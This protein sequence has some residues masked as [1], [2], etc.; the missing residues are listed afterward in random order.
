MRG[1]RLRACSLADQSGQAAKG[2]AEIDQW[3][4]GSIGE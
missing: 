3:K 1:E 4:P 2:D